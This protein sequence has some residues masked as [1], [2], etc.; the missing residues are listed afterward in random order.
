MLSLFFAL[1]R[2]ITYY[3]YSVVK[4]SKKEEKFAKM[5]EEIMIIAT[6]NCSIYLQF[7]LLL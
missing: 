2:G 5:P 1:S 4:L 7:V 6:L 3:I